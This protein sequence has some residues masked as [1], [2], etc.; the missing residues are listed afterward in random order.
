MPSAAERA[1]RLATRIPLLVF[2]A[3]A[4]AA[5]MGGGGSGWERAAHPREQTAPEIEPT[6]RVDSAGQMLVCKGAAIEGF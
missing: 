6:R 5:E 3:A 1:R 4:T 2:A